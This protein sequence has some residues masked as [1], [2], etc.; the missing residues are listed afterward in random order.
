MLEIA[1]K[2]HVPLK[3]QVI[4]CAYMYILDIFVVQF[5]RLGIFYSYGIKVSLHLPPYPLFSLFR[6]DYMMKRLPNFAYFWV[7]R[8]YIK[9]PI[10]NTFQ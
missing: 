2:I 1:T 9:G 5:A 6:S 8:P 10:P 4:I 7:N 3:M